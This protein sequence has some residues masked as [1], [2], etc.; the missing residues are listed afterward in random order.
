MR[1][2]VV[3]YVIKTR[4][5]LGLPDDHPWLLI[6]DVFKAQWTNSVKYEVGQSFGKMTP[7]PNNWTSY[8]QPLDISVNKPCKD[9]LRNE[10]QTWYSDKI[11]EQLKAGKL[12]H[13]VKEVPRFRSSN[14]CMKSEY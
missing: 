4:E 3:P 12:S 7:V 8:F 2:I 10:A 11:M 9:L 14:L 1:K 13:V 5:E 6:C